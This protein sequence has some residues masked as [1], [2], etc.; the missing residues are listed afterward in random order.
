[1]V[2]TPKS[3]TITQL[4]SAESEQYVVP[5]Y[6]RRYPWHGKQL[7]ELLD[8]ISL[9]G[10]ADTHLLGS[11]VC[12]TGYHKAGTN[13]LELVDG[14][15]RLTTIC[16]LLQCIADRFRKDGEL[17]ASQD[18]DRLLQARALG[19]PPVR[20]IRSIR[21]IRKTFNMWLKY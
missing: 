1:M 7:W 16:L 4:L 19:E 13:E 18:I 3:P 6:Q 14:Q 15:Q 17:S 11:L 10:G 9:L 20:K 2:L 21:S 12:L 8:D 5:A